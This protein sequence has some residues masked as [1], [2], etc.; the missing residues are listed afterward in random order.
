MGET[1]ATAT[2]APAATPDATNPATET[3]EDKGGAP[4]V[5][6]PAAEAPGAVPETEVAPPAEAK[7]EAENPRV[8]RAFAEI[9]KR[10]RALR[11]KEAS[12]KA[13]ETEV[14]SLRD[15]ESQVAKDPLSLLQKFPDLY[16][17]LTESILRQGEAPAEPTVD[18]K[19][20]QLEKRLADK[21]AAEVEARK[22]AEQAEITRKLD[23]ARENLKRTSAT[24]PDRWELVNAEGAH[25]TAWGVLEAYWDQHQKVLPFE[26]ALD[27]V[28]N[29]LLEER[30][31]LL[32]LKKIR[33][34]MAPPAAKAP[35]AAA[36]AKPAPTASGKSAS[37]TL[38]SSSFSEAPVL[39]SAWPADD[40][41]SVKKAA[42][43]I[44][45]TD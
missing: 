6:A 12:I 44:R 7:P 14:A 35:A 27:Y 24:D 16:E 5:E 2:E 34:R 36:G 26:D 8:S 41:Q 15:L 19:I 9:T 37:P 43:L 11:E 25:D 17:R 33:A 30:G 42:S 18:D 21:E 45:F 3:P 13:R 32:N 23:N 10:E 31:K 38:T 1:T 4:A 22:A 28:E 40:S 29:H 39:D 20:A